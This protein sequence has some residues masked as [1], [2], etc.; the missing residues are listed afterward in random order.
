[1]W[2]P[3]LIGRHDAEGGSIP[4]PEAGG[5]VCP[6]ARARLGWAWLPERLRRLGRV[7]GV[8][9]EVVSFRAAIRTKAASA[10]LRLWSFFVVLRVCIVRADSILG[11]CT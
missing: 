5:A 4:G 6:L 7:G 1:M 9:M 8:L 10:R 3:P 2:S 11:L